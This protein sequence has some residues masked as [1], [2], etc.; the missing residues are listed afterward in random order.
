MPEYQIFRLREIS[1]HEAVGLVGTN[2]PPPYNADGALRRP[3]AMHESA[4]QG[5][6][7]TL[8]P[9]DGCSQLAHGAREFEPLLQHGI[10]LR[11]LFNQ[12]SAGR[13]IAKVFPA[14]GGYFLEDGVPVHDDG[15]PLPERSHHRHDIRIMV[16]GQ[17]NEL[18]SM[19]PAKL[20]E[21]LP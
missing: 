18:D 19:E 3:E 14:P 8:P 20:A 1:I 10:G 12:L 11:V 15:L 16:A 9:H 7:D 4:K 5:I 6:A 2:Y 13:L 17:L 21:L